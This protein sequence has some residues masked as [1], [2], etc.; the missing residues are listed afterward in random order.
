MLMGNK[1]LD[2][3]K[4]DLSN[5]FATKVRYPK[6]DEF[7]GIVE[8]RLGC[9]RMTI[10]KMDGTTCMA[11]VPGRMRKFLWIR[12]GNIVL[13]EPWKIEKE[14]SDLIYKF[15]HNEIK[16]LEKQGLLENLE[17]VEGF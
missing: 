6:G 10:R 1:K 2:K 14:K 17:Q 12:E 13:L 16:K 11:T 3:K 5:G 7:I 4:K 15:S 9:S 8:K